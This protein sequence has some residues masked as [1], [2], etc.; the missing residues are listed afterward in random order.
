MRIFGKSLAEY[1]SFTRGFLILILV[2]GLG[3]LLLSI[4]GV[5]NSAV[6]FLSLT[7]LFLV[8]MFYYSVR[9]YTTGFGSYKQL[10]PVLALQVIAG[11]SI[12]ILGIVIA[13]LTGRENIFS[14][15]EYSPGK[16]SGGTWGHVAGHL[17]AMIV[18]P[19][20]LWLLGSLVMFVTKKVSGGRR[21]QNQGAARV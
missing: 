12:V 14:I 1:L 11:E 19:L 18:F 8:G 15:P 4:L 9:V 21:E 3:R 7:V 13:I 16:A 10:L 17:V 6:K 2:V 20:V 5:P